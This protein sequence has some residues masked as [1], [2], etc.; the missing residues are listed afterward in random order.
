MLVSE[1]PQ[2][3]VQPAT[4]TTASSSVPP[5]AGLLAPTDAF[6]RRH[7][8]P[9]SQQASEMLRLLRCERLDDLVHQAVPSKIRLRRPLALPQGKSEF[10]VLAEL[11]A[12]AAQNQIYRSFIGMGYS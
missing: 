9:D 5:S 4:A 1:P 2:K 8:G 3:N 7:I 12:I 6:P 10:E 11:K